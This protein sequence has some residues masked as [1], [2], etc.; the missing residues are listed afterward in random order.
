MM[1]KLEYTHTKLGEDVNCPA[2]YYTPNKEVRLKYKYREILYVVGRAVVDSSCC[3]F[4]N[5]TYVSVP[6]YIINWKNKSSDA[7][8]PVSEVEPIYGKAAKEE[9]R[10]IVIEAESVSQVEFW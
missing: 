9:I 10:R 5:W 4:G 7:G 8:L 6:G 2:G 1:E 3:G